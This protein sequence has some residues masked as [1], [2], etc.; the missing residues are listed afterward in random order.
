MEL[1]I[2]AALAGPLGYFA[3]TRRIALI[4]YLAVWAVVLPIQ[5][6]VVHNENPDDINWQY[7]LVNAVILGTGIALNQ[8]GASLRAR[9]RSPRSTG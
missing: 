3:P 9:Q 7:A 1:I 5:T 8:L 6:I 4:S 2:A